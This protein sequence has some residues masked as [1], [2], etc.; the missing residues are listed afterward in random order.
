VALSTGTVSPVVLVGPASAS[1]AITLTTAAGGS[2]AAV[3]TGAAS[4]A[5]TLTTGTGGVGT[6]GGRSGS[7]ILQTGAGAATNGGT[8]H[9]V[10][11]C[12]APHGTGV[13]GTVVRRFAS[14]AATM[15]TG[16]LTPALAAAGLLKVTGAGAQTLTL[17]TGANFDTAFPTLST[18]DCIEVIVIN[19]TA[20]AA[21]AITFAD[22]ANMVGQGVKVQSVASYNSRLIIY[23]TGAGTW[24]YAVIG[25]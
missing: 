2:G 4:G 21:G 15:T 10:F 19:N 25:V 6:T 7:I 11:G 12:G 17:D 1:G 13:A 22:A 5:V 20:A 3:T 23:K 9:I 18:G 24:E 16:T 8:G 14:L